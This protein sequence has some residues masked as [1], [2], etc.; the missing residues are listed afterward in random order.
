MFLDVSCELSKNFLTPNV[1]EYTLIYTPI[2]LAPATGEGTRHRSPPSDRG[3][4][5]VERGAVSVRVT[6]GAR[7]L[8]KARY[9]GESGTNDTLI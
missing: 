8:Q 7:T 9:K 5:A 3:H 2:R 6:A 1:R 4:A